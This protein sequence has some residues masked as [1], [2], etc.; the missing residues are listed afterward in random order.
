MSKEPDLPGLL[1]ASISQV[2]GAK[3]WLRL[4]PFSL[5]PGE[6]AKIMLIGFTA[7]FLVAKRELFR[8]AGRRMLGLEF[9][10]PR[11]LAHET[12]LTARGRESRRLT[13][14]IRTV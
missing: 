11:D 9:P 13:A 8:V 12:S 3:L 6:F 5:Q 2:N 1:P 14:V 7:A 4:G 10:R